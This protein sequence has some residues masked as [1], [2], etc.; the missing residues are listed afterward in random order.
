MPLK[1]IKAYKGQ[2]IIVAERRGGV[3]KYG[4]RIV[5]DGIKYV[6]ADWDNKGDAEEALATLIVSVRNPEEYHQ[7]LDLTIGDLFDAWERRAKALNQNVKRILD[8]K[9]TLMRL[10]SIVKSQSLLKITQDDLLN[11]QAMRVRAGKHNHTVNREMAQI[12]TVFL[13]A[14]SLFPGFKWIPPKVERYHKLPS[15]HEGRDVLINPHDHLKI[16]AA[17]KQDAAVLMPTEKRERRAAAEIRREND[18]RAYTLDA[19]LVASDMAL[20]ISE[21]AD[22]KKTDVQFG[23]GVRAP[24]GSIRF[25]SSKTYK[26]QNVP[27]T[28]AVARILKRR[29]E[30]WPGEYLFRNDGQSHRMAILKIRRGFKRACERAG[31]VYG[32]KDDGIVFHT[33]RHT[34]ATRLINQGIPLSTVAE[35]TR[36]SKK[37]M[38]MRYSH[39]TPETMLKAIEAMASPEIPDSDWTPFP[40]RAAKQQKNKAGKS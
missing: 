40:E 22:L 15:F 5:L 10:K 21:L 34:L 16:I 8:V 2:N 27:M 23:R 14:D 37:T 20:R 7:Q 11:Y 25:T 38:L 24:H 39:S 1:I 31:L 3:K 19:Y 12:R 30:E 18:R 33:I 26:R 35:I 6:R 28:P 29:S 9:A 13:A 36:H 32:F 17:L 4:Y